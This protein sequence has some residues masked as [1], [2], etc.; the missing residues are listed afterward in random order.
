MWSS[1]LVTSCNLM[2]LLW[3]VGRFCCQ[4]RTLCD[5]FPSERSHTSASNSDSLA[6]WAIVNPAVATMPQQGRQAQVVNRNF[7][8]EGLGLFGHCASFKSSP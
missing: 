6:A 3:N 8:E 7:F 1:M 5:V 2:Q 4:N